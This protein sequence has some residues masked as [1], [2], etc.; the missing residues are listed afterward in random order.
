MKALFLGMK[1][2]LLFLPLLLLSCTQEN[3]N[4]L[5]HALRSAHPAILNVAHNPE[6]YEIQI[7]FSQIERDSV[8]NA[9]FTDHSFRLNENNY[10]YPAS[11]VKLPMV[12]VALEFASNNELGIRADTPY[13]TSRDT[14]IHTIGDDMWKIFAVSDNEAYNRLYELLGRDEVNRRL[15]KLELGPVRLSHRLST[16]N[17]N[18]PERDTLQFIV[19]GDTIRVGG[20]ADGPI[21]S[22]SLHG[23]LKGKGFIRDGKRVNQPMD[24]SEKN[25][26]PLKTQHNI[27]K[28]IIAPESAPN[29]MFFK[30]SG[31]NGQAFNSAIHTVPRKAGYDEE[32]Y[33]D[34]YGK[35]FIYGDSKERIPD[36]IK[37]YNKVGYAYG[38]LTE[39][40]YIT[41]ET[42][43]IEFLLSATI[44][45][46]EN[47]IFNDDTYEYDEIGIPFLAQLGR[48]L[49]T[50][51]FVRKKKK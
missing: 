12:L 41:D 39:T 34:S 7:L 36:D 42:N 45:V 19:E 43:G 30:I 18:V 2:S 24:F 51:E 8:G 37:I 14:L 4:P 31:L 22:L 29:G 15:R 26:F 11:T 13:L 5:E 40:A 27:M 17:S 10:F 38:T 1:R 20:P 32:E 28:R 33:Y 25:Y 48:E 21:E 9:V 23:Q 49:Y 6:K 16:P 46:N 50:Q 35:F 3:L 47:G 44:L